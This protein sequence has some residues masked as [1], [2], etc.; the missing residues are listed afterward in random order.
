MA[1]AL[2]R[3]FLFVVMFSSL[4][5]NF[6]NSHWPCSELSKEIQS[7]SAIQSFAARTGGVV[8][9]VEDEELA[10]RNDGVPALRKV[11]AKRDVSSRPRSGIPWQ[12]LGKTDIIGRTL[13]LYRVSNRRFG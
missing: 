12:F 3:P 8:A 6:E 2:L 9:F 4:R 1:G 10:P 5:A 11:K 13:A 7:F